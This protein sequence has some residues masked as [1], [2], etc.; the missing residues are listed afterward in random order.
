MPIRTVG[1]PV[2]RTPTRVVPEV[3][4]KLRAL[5]EDMF[6]TMYEAPGVGLAGN[7]VGIELSLTVIDCAGVKAVLI[8]PQITYLSE[9]IETDDEGCLSVPGYHFPTPRAAKATVSA[10]NEFGEPVELTGTGL[11]ARCFQHEV[12]HLNGRLYLDRLPGKV[13]GRAWAE[14]EAGDRRR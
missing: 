8:N 14:I 11:L 2:L 7:Q 4:D 1:D 13:R 5:I 9:E 3:D 10:L 6:E 12:D